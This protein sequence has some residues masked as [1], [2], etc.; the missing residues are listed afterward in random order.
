MNLVANMYLPIDG[1]GIIFYAPF[2]V[3][4]IQEKEDYMKEHYMYYEADQIQPHVEQGTITCFGT[5][6]PGRY[7]LDIFTGIPDEA[8]L[9]TYQF[10]L[11]LGLVVKDQTVC[12]RD[13]YDLMYWRANCPPEQVIHL[14]DGFYEVFLASNY[15]TSGLIGDEH[16]I[17]MWFNQVDQ[18]PVLRFDDIPALWPA[19][20]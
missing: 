19:E 5:W 20:E 18:L 13:L 8:I 10:Q 16:H 14:S 1:L 6:S 4:H 7:F 17:A 12:F 15:P 9:A 3:A 11:K 2:A